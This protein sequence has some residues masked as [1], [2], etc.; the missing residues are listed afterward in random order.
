[1]GKGT[2]YFPSCKIF[3]L[4]NRTL[5]FR[6]SAEGLFGTGSGGNILFRIFGGAKKRQTMNGTERSGWI[7]HAAALVCV[8]V[9]G[10]TFV[11]TKVLINCGLTPLDIFLARF[12]LAYLC[13]WPFSRRL[14]AASWRD[15]ALLAAMGLTGGSVYFLTENMAVGMAPAS[16]VSLLVT[17]AP[18]LTLL[19]LRL[20]RL[21][22]ALRS[23]QL[24][25]SA[26]AFAGVA[27][28]VF[29][30]R[31]VL[32]LSP[33]G[34][35]L[36]L[37]AALMWA[38]Y[39]LLLRR[40]SERYSDVFLMR[41]VFFYGVATALPVLAFSPLHL[42]SAWMQPV[43]WGNLLFLGL[44]ASMGCYLLWTAVMRRLGTMRATN[45]IYFNPLVTLL[46]AAAVLGERITLIALLGAALILPGVWLAGLKN[47]A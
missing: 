11:A 34:D 39:S 30:G 2:R 20:F 26:I 32:R 25:G 24:W 10:T 19:L 9:W 42:S 5:P 45:Y 33:A 16:N 43:V 6:A 35:L 21:S 1:M 13:L 40:L 3:P 46:T 18:V 15:E 41:K 29:N 4:K 23:T 14:F 28:V 38:F 31:F 27:C 37:T 8:G 7:W 12:L 36:A 47:G 22:G 44:V 17:T